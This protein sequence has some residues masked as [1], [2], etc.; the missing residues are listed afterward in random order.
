M[1]GERPSLAR[2]VG[3]NAPALGLK[4]RASTSSSFYVAN[5]DSSRLSGRCVNTHTRES[6]KRVL[7]S[8]GG[9]YVRPP[10]PGPM[11]VN[12]P[13]QGPIQVSRNCKRSFTSTSPA[14]FLPEHQSRVS[15][16][17]TTELNGF[18]YLTHQTVRSVFLDRAREKVKFL[19]FPTH[20]GTPSAV[21]L[22]ASPRP[23]RAY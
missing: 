22:C 4:V 7:W 2:R 10:R 16:F 6:T 20:S 19:T 15:L 14:W 23:N 8:I 1:S 9:L 21:P 5:R 11:I 18:Q 3:M 12:G 17:I 13:D